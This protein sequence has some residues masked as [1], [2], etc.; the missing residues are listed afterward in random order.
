MR[1][2][3]RCR[4][5]WRSPGTLGSPRSA[6]VID[7][8][9]SDPRAVVDHATRLGVDLVVVGPEAPLVAGVG[10]ALRADGLHVFGPD[11][12]AARIEGSKSYAKDLMDR[13][14]IPTGRARSFDE[15]EAAV[16]FLDELG[17]PYVIKADG[18]A[19]GKGV[20]VTTERADALAAIDDR[21]VHGTFGEAGSTVVI[22]EFLDGEEASVIAFTDG[23][24]SSCVSRHRTTSA[25]S[26]ATRSQHRWDG[27]LQS[28]SGLPSGPGRS[29]RGRSSRADG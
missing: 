7:G 24:A 3:A 6:E 13:A 5:W 9:P 29:H 26:M 8:D 11:A 12:A 28:R 1:A 17:P 16:A 4:N 14:G 2:R 27:F 10:D 18:L 19:A 21:L 15:P 23:E 22:E 25:S 20:V